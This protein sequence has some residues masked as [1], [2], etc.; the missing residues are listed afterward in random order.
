MI[1]YK[2]L[3]GTDTQVQTVLNQWRHIYDLTIL[4]FS[5]E[6]TDISILLTRTKKEKDN[7]VC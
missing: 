1:E 4:G 3:H 6:A 5:V 7:N 2:I